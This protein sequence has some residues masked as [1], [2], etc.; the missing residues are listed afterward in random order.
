MT[1]TS[2]LLFGDNFFLF[3]VVIMVLIAVTDLI[4]GVSND[5]VNFLNSAIGSNA[6]T[7]RQIMIVASLGV[8]LGSAFSGGMMEVA[9]KGVFNPEFFN[10]KEVMFLFAAVMLTD[11]ILLDFYNSIALPTST[12]VS[13]VFELLGAAIAVSF[14]SVVENGHTMDEWSNYINGSGAAFIILG[15]FLSVII[16]FTLGWLVQYITRLI[17]SF[18]YTRTMRT[19]GSVFGSTSVAL[20]IA[21]IVLKGLK[22]MPFLSESSLNYIKE[23]A[24]VAS[25]AGFGI[26][27][28]AFQ[29]LIA[30]KNFDVYRFITM[31]GT[32][33]LAMAFA[34]NDLVNFIGVPIASFDAYLNWSE[35]GLEPEQFMMTSLA[36]PVRSNLVI[37]FLA[38][39]IM[40]LTLWFSKKSKSVV[41]TSVDLG[42]QVEG[43]ERFKPNFLSRYVVKVT[44][45]V[46]SAVNELLPNP[47]IE[48]IRKRF[49]DSAIAVPNKP[50]F[51][52]VRASI[53]LIVAAGLI[54]V[55]TSMKLPLSTT[56]VS[57]MVL[58]GTSLADRAWAQ[59]SA[60]YRVTGVF[61]VIGGWLLT[62]VS[63]M[64]VSM[65]FASLLVLFEGYALVGLVISAVLLIFKNYFFYREN[66]YKSEMNLAMADEWFQS[67]FHAIESEVRKKLSN[68]LDRVDRAYSETIDALIKGDSKE[69]RR[70]SALFRDV[71][72]T[73]D[74][75]KVKLTQQIKEV[76]DSHREGGKIL[77]LIY[78]LEDDLVYSLI[79]IID[80]CTRHVRN[81]HP[82]LHAEQVEMLQKSKLE[83]TKYIKQILE[84]L[85]N[86]S[87]T[88]VDYNRF[89]SLRRGLI[90][91]I[92][93]GISGQIILASREKI[94][95]KNSDLL[96]TFL[97]SSKN[98][99][100]H[101]SSLLKIFRE[102]K[103]DDTEKIVSPGCVS[104]S[105]LL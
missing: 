44:I 59:G 29:V 102:V 52:Q 60:V 9:R 94:S 72:S 74:L 31:F 18:N 27:F 92:D 55:A 85:K 45:A 69:L 97:F 30:R 26:S 21:F 11:I 89:I 15:I 5:A 90:R 20:I 40:T 36:E 23:K 86:D 41:Q 78:D 99:I 93:K 7:F 4:V 75:Y 17:V 42:R 91:H 10:F 67:D 63:A 14:F 65:I 84:R 88:E 66:R 12:T 87:I 28:V 16:A 49:S 98:I 19:L 54:L 101:S 48:K 104:S 53:N 96:L 70:L 6:G 61:T 37:L 3:I 82:D 39:V 22:G 83:I 46:H 62:A 47:T 35:S 73:N 80:S 2:T 32:F 50:A 58:M 68:I 24:W 38:G 64:V 95:G 71:E 56:F 103:G 8:L 51:D 76:P 105:A 34:S 57:F 43:S 33:A 79:N 25:L 1:V 100:S 81:L 77:M 13:I